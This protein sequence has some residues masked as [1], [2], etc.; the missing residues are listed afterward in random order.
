MLLSFWTHYHCSSPL[1]IQIWAQGRGAIN[2]YVLK[3]DNHVQIILI[4]T[5]S[6]P[7]AAMLISVLVMLQGWPPTIIA[8]SLGSTEPKLFPY[9]INRANACASRSEAI[10]IVRSSKSRFAMNIMVCAIL[11]WGSRQLALEKRSRVQAP[12]WD[13]IFFSFP[14]SPS[15]S[16]RHFNIQAFFYTMPWGMCVWKPKFVRLIFG[17]DLHTKLI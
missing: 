3:R 10:I 5:L 12:L 8:N 1:T 13:S 2:L 17:L 15:C 14:F 4:L 9:K 7:M 11:P 6:F 16:L